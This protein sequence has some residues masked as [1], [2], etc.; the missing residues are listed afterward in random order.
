MAHKICTFLSHCF[1]KQM[2]SK[3][4]SNLLILNSSILNDFV[5]FGHLNL[6]KCEIFHTENSNKNYFISNLVAKM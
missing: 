5:Q 1:C 2:G 3:G 6:L 4:K